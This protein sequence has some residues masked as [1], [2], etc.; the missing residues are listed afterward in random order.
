MNS[1]M[2]NFYKDDRNHMTDCQNS[3]VKGQD[4]E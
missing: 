4:Y 1:R 2:I 3:S